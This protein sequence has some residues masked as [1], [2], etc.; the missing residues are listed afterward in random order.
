MIDALHAILTN[1]KARTK[2]SIKV[3][4]AKSM[5]ADMTPWL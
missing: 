5:S 3:R 2:K 1:S 4:L